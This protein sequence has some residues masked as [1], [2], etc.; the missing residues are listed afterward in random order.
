MKTLLKSVLFA[1][2]LLSCTATFA[3]QKKSFE[4]PKNYKFES[5][6]DYKQYDSLI[7]VAANW[8]QKLKLDQWK[9]KRAEADK[10]VQAWAENNPNVKIE[11]NP[12]IVTFTEANPEL[13]AVFITGWAKYALTHPED[14]SVEKGC[15]AGLK[16]VCKY[17]ETEVNLNKD[18]QVE[19]LVKMNNK[20][21]LR[22]WVKE[23]MKN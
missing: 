11:L 5:S 7:I 16:A 8:Y 9:E 6:E 12:K 23:Q 2:F 18:K 22:K 19:A 3:Q 4:V 15:V 10:F 21:E 14:Q 20:N 17:Y 1:V 13:N